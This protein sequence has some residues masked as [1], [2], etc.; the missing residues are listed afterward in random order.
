[1]YVI[2]T[3]LFLIFFAAS[4][5]R[6]E[7]SKCF[8]DEPAQAPG[9]VRISGHVEYVALEGGYFRIV[10]CQGTTYLPSN[11][12]KWGYFQQHRLRIRALLR[13]IEVARSFRMGGATAV[14]IIELERLEEK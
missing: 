14:V 5:A 1:M 6:V 4:F 7:A 10:D 2:K 8:Y 12:D 13:K 9:I 3:A 11:F